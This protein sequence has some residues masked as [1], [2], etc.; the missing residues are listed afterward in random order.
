[1]HALILLQMF[2]CSAVFDATREKF[3]NIQ[4]ASY[5]F[6]L[7][8]QTDTQTWRETATVR[9]KET[10][11]EDRLLPY[12]AVRTAGC[13]VDRPCVRSA[14]AQPARHSV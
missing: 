5:S 10:F 7:T 4:S 1:M 11:M 6:H 13:S 2:S 3:I 8:E 9:D 14:S 12:L